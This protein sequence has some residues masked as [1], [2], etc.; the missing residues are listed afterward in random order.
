MK[1][2]V[3]MKINGGIQNAFKNKYSNRQFIKV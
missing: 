2:N 3:I 1:I